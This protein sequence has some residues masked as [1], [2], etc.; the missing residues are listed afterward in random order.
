[1]PTLLVFKNGE[2]TAIQIGALPKVRLA[3]WIKR[4]V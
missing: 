4:A 3:E 2:P 1:M